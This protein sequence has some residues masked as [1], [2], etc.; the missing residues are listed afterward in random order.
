MRLLLATCLA[1]LA[2]CPV[3]AAAAGSTTPSGGA[4]TP[5]EGGAHYGETPKVHALASLP[6][7]KLFKLSGR[8]LSATVSFRIAS[9]RPVRDVRLQLLGA[10]GG[11]VVKTLM[12]GTR[13]S[14]RLYKVAV[15]KTGLAAGSYRIRITA[16]QLRTAGIASVARVS[17]PKPPPAKPA[18]APVPVPVSGYVFPV[19]G[20][21][22]FGGA[23]AGFGAGRSGHR[24]QGQDI[25]AAEGTPVVAPHGG[26]VEAVRYQASGAGHYIVL[27]GAGED[28][29]YV[30]MH[31]AT[32]TT[33]VREGQAVSV[34]QQ[35]AQVGNT[36]ASFGA[37]LHFEIWVG[38]GWYTGGQPIDPLPL[39][40]SWAAAG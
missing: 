14:G 16:R 37:H 13:R 9:A 2:V 33:L 38:G 6:H 5:T 28:R 11:A 24:H 36:G 22:T 39:L 25:P 27:D 34:G 19:R 31:L 7:L 20:P 1:G 29:D 15:P 17:V 30:F 4:A 10:R 18:P 26:T 3:T 12:L 8:T 21:Y 35:L 23:D 32:A 40:R